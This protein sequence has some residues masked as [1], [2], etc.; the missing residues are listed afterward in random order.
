MLMFTLKKARVFLP[1]M[2]FHPSLIFACEV[3]STFCKSYL[4]LLDK[5]SSLFV[6]SVVEEKNSL[7]DMRPAANVLNNLRS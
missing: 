1:V 4:Q 3:C 6:P 5:H 2:S 7:I